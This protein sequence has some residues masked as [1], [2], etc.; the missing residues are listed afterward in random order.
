MVTIVLFTSSFMVSRDALHVKGVEDWSPL[1]QPYRSQ[2]D[3]QGDYLSPLKPCKIQ[4]SIP[5]VLATRIRCAATYKVRYE[6]PL[7]VLRYALLV[8]TV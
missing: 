6:K 2:T 7:T 5:L 4:Q 3:L 1:L 8:S